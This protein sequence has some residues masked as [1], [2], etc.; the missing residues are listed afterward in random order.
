[1]TRAKPKPKKETRSKT[2]AFRVKPSEE[3]GL[4]I[5]A[6]IYQ[7]D[8]NKVCRALMIDFLARNKFTVDEYPHLNTYYNT[9]KK[10]IVSMPKAVA[11]KC[12]PSKLDR[13]LLLEF[14]DHLF[15]YSKTFRDKTHELTGEY[16]QP[17][18]TYYLYHY[19]NETEPVGLLDNIEVG[20]GEETSQITEKDFIKALRDGSSDYHRNTECLLMKC[21]YG[22]I[23][24]GKFQE[25]LK[26]AYSNPKFNGKR[27]AIDPSRKRRRYLNRV[28]GPIYVEGD[29]T[30]GN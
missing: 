27:L 11:V 21:V 16:G 26:D 4:D 12:P 3:C 23:K 10:A 14:A 9:L 20:Y 22:F 18:E 19:P 7:L 6:G 13:R 30:H 15:A 2:I 5:L 24:N 25:I 29:K 1:M 28:E 8:S 17:D